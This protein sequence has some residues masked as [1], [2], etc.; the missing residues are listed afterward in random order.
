M[1]YY[2]TIAYLSS[3]S[4]LNLFLFLVEIAELSLADLSRDWPWP[5]KKPSRVSNVCDWPWPITNLSLSVPARKSTNGIRQMKQ[6]RTEKMN[7]FSG[8]VEIVNFRLCVV[9]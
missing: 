5:I 2:G 3:C 9:T 1:T 7:I 6:A 4:L 8:P